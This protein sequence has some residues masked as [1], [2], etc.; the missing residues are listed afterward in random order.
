MAFSPREPAGEAGWAGLNMPCTVD[1]S[2]HS[3]GF[4]WAARFNITDVSYSNGNSNS[5]NEG[6]R[7]YAA[8]AKYAEWG[9][10]RS[11]VSGRQGPVPGYGG[12]KPSGWAAWVTGRGGY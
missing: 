11:G 6:V 2:G 3:K 12:V 8:A 10:A 7:A 9:Q 5:F 4:Q 1:C